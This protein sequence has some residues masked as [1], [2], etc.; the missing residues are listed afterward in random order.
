[1]DL[2]DNAAMEDYS[3]RHAPASFRT[4]SPWM[5]FLTSW[6]ALSAMAGYA[7]DAAYING[8]GFANALIG[9]AVASLVTLPLVWV[10]SFRI[11]HSHLDIDLLT[12]ASGFGYLGS[13]VTSLVYAG[14]TLIFLAFEGSLMAQAVTAASGLDIHWSYVLVSVIMIPLT[15][16]GMSF[17]TR[18]QSWTW[19]VWLVLI[20][21]A[22]V[23][24][25]TSPHAFDH[26]VDGGAGGSGAGGAVGISL[27]GVL[28][29]AAA[30]LA[31]AAQVGEQGDYLRLM[32]DV[33]PQNRRS[34]R[35]GVF[36]GGPGVG[37]MVVGIFFASAVLIGYATGRIGAASAVPVDLFT[38]V[39]QRA[40]GGNHAA[41]LA[42][43]VVLVIVAQLKINIMNT[44]SGS[45]SWSN[46]FSR[47]LHRHPGRPVWVVWQ[48]ALAVVLMELNIFAHIVV[49]LEWFANIAI[50]WIAALASDL[51]INKKWL[52]L[53]PGDIEFKRAHLYNI[54]PVGFGSM[55]IAATV[56]MLAYYDV[57]GTTAKELSAFLAL[58]LAIVLPPLV[59]RATG[60]RFYIAR[61]SELPE[62]ATSLTCVRCEQDFEVPDMAQCPF[63]D[64]F[65]CSLCCST[66]GACHDACKPN[67]WRPTS[68]VVGIGMPAIRSEP[69]HEPVGAMRREARLRGVAES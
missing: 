38:T 43:A 61:R 55:L 20:G 24:A 27:I 59:A 62:G 7:L 40:F 56:A 49:V 54:N 64:G 30:N 2:A 37:I 58:A 13:T 65:I 32:P 48:V 12:R 14:Y 21:I 52:R 9:F 33:T 39:F 6:V 31:T 42:C 3:L 51:V 36:F 1:M 63:H 60:G 35:L 17:T 4:W 5:V 66:D 18:F 11:A 47:V 8:F 44:Y 25:A 15:V 10:L 57:F 53:A 68:K 34:W 69:V 29:V 45:L 26:M 16:Y 22:V 67:A 19:P 46:F 41:A 28:T 50:A 23:T